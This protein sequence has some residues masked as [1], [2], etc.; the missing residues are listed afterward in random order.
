MRWFVGILMGLALILMGCRSS[1]NP[2][3]VTAPRSVTEVAPER[4]PVRRAVE[5]RLEPLA[6]VTP[7]GE[8]PSRAQEGPSRPKAGEGRQTPRCS[9]VL[10]SGEPEPRRAEVPWYAGLAYLVVFLGL[11]FVLTWAVE[12]AGT[13]VAPWCGRIWASIWCYQHRPK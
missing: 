7:Q 6:D 2:A 13:R 8:T 10:A 1:C 5:P 11:V 9:L 4:V 3:C 12:F